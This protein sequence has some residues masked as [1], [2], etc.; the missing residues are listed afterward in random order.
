ML[1]KD[2]LVGVA[3]TWLT[4]TP[5][6]KRFRKKVVKMLAD[7]YLLPKENKDKEVKENDAQ[8]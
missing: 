8:T 3:V 2:L 5:E 7:Q 1:V 4:V 6:G